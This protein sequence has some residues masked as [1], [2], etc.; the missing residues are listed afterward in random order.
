[1]MRRSRSQS[2]R[3]SSPYVAE[4]T[5]S[6]SGDVIAMTSHARTRRGR[7]IALDLLNREGRE[8][9]TQFA[10]TNERGFEKIVQRIAS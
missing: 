5:L 1:M 4:I 3:R 9:S 10:L 7:T 2:K 6:L 8:F